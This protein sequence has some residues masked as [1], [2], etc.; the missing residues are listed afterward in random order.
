MCERYEQQLV[1]ALLLCAKYEQKLVEAL[2]LCARYEQRFLPSSGASGASGARG[3]P[4][5]T[6]DAATS[7]EVTRCF[8]PKQCLHYG[9]LAFSRAGEGTPSAPVPRH[10]KSLTP[11]FVLKVFFS[12][13]GAGA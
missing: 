7:S 10:A 5:P 8:F 2:L 4:A 11:F 9:V 12:K 3:A 6:L 13:K 1:E